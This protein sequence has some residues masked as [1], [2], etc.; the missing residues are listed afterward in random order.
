MQ[1][2]AEAVKV[3]I[4]TIISLSILAYITLRIGLPFLSSG[5]TV[6]AEFLNAANVNKNTK[7][8]VG[9]IKEGRVRDIQ[10]KDNVA[11]LTLQVGKDVKL[12]NDLHIDVAANS[13]LGERQLAITPGTPAAGRYDGQLLDTRS[14]DTG[15]TVEDFVSGLTPDVLRNSNV[16]PNGGLTTFVRSLNAALG[17]RTDD[18]NS[19]FAQ[20][21]RLSKIGNEILA[22]PTEARLGD[23]IDQYNTVSNALA[24]RSTQISSL[25]NNLDS[26]V[27]NLASKDKQLVSLIDGLTSVF[28]NFA[29][30]DAEL[31][32]AIDSSSSFFVN[33]SSQR[34]NLTRL[35]KDTTTFAGPLARNTDQTTASITS[36]ADLLGIL[37]EQRLAIARFLNVFPEWGYN[38]AVAIEKHN[39]LPLVA[40]NVTMDLPAPLPIDVS[41]LPSLPPIQ[42]PGLP[43]SVPTATVPAV[44]VP[45]P[46]ATVT[47]PPIP[48][49]TVPLPGAGS[50]ADTPQ[51]PA[52]GDLPALPKIPKVTFPTG[53]ARPSAEPSGGGSGDAPTKTTP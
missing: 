28:G 27:G 40:E 47:T 46:G 39:A 6:K 44:T 41:N 36:T 7:V 1:G 8:K 33:L 3:L 9:G 34:Q 18:L 11:I 21:N 14:T 31:R 32:R 10:V 35:V 50:R 25:V 42:V 16:G 24:D 37:A 22:G 45:L 49:P 48:T 23:L 26:S 20:A 12:F 13:A 17:G 43:T 5:Q 15:Q 52:L 19:F 53:G 29:A 30:K 51:A 38:N 2:R 4:F